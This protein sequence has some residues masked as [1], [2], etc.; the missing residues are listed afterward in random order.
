MKDDA[1]FDDALGK[2][3][4]LRSAVA[5]LRDLGVAEHAKEEGSRFGPYATPGSMHYLPRPSRPENFPRSA[6]ML[7]K[8]RNC[9]SEMPNMLAYAK[10]NRQFPQTTAVQSFDE[11]QWDAYFRLG[12]LIGDR[13][14]AL[15]PA[16]GPTWQP[17]QMAA[18]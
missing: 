8:P 6:F 1:Q 12:E 9:G 14:F 2:M 18:L 13:L 10:Q 4:A 7:I 3:T 17:H 16:R 11:Q 5:P 15:Q